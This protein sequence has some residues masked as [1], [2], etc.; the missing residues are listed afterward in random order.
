MNFY[1]CIDIPYLPLAENHAVLE[2]TTDNTISESGLVKLTLEACGISTSHLYRQSEDFLR[3]FYED[4]DIDNLMEPR[5]HYYTGIGR[6]YREFRHLSEEAGL[7]SLRIIPVFCTV[8]DLFGN[9]VS[10]VKV[11]S[12]DEEEGLEIVSKLR[13]IANTI[14]VIPDKMEFFPQMV[15]AV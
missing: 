8:L 3:C 14:L 12:E 5:V 10:F 4:D 7:R 11:Y 13:G 9:C 6:D 1:G 15:N 2:I